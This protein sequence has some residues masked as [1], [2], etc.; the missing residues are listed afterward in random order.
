[1]AYIAQNIMAFILYC[2]Q[3]TKRDVTSDRK[4]CRFA[5]FLLEKMRKNSRMGRTKYFPAQILYE[6]RKQGKTKC[7]VCTTKR[8]TPKY[9]DTMLKHTDNHSS[10]GRIAVGHFP[11]VFHSM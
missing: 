11:K 9:G 6:E 7:G 10:L 8:S 2:Q 4:I 1:M 3:T 5:V